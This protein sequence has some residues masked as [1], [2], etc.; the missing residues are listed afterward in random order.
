MSGRGG[1]PERLFAPWRAAY[2]RGDA[3]DGQGE[4]PFCRLVKAPPARHRDLGV[5]ARGRHGLVVLNRYPYQSGHLLILPRAHEHRLPDLSSACRHE[6]DDWLV[7]AVEA[8]E[9]A[10]GC[11][12]VNV[13]LNQGTA[14]G[15]GVAEHLHWH[16]VPR[17]HGDH[18]FMPVLSGTDVLPEDPQQ[19]YDRLVDWFAAEGEDS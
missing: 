12:G 2:V 1:A 14:A 18:N 16:A 11:H 5:L 8:L 7:R 9:G 13:G 19:T 15:A 3:D 6:L 17:W 10:M 4:C